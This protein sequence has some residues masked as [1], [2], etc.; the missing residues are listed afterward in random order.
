MIKCRHQES[1]YA[2]V[3]PEGA[4]E[5]TAP[6]FQKIRYLSAICFEEVLY[7]EGS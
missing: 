3:Y 5:A 7:K 6:P 1:L 4:R 2:G